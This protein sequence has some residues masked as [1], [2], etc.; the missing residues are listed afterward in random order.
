LP[1]LN[2]AIIGQL[3]LLQQQF[4]EVLIPS[5]VWSELKP[6]TTFP[7]ATTM[8]ML[9]HQAGFF[10]ADDLFKQVLQEAGEL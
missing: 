10:I 5:A 9:R 6:E 2:L 3:D 7:D 8:Q 4:A 1:I